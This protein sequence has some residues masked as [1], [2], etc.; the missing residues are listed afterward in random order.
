MPPKP[1]KVA[2]YINALKASSRMADQ[3]VTHRS[4]PKS[5]AQYGHPEAPWPD[6]I[7]GIL[8]EAGVKKLFKHQVQAID[9]IRRGENIVA[10]TP[11]A[12]GKTFM[13][14]LPVLEALAQDPGAHALYMFPLKALTQDQIK[15]FRK[16]AASMENG[17]TA[18]IY[19]GDTTSY[20]RRKI[21][22]APPNAI[23][24]NP[25][26]LHLGFLPYH[27]NWEGFFG[28]LKYIVVDE[29]HTYRGVMGSHMAW[30][31]ARLLRVCR[32]YGSDP[33]FVMCSAT[34]A[35]PRD[36]ACR[37]TGRDFKLV[38]K[39][40]APRGARHVVFMNP[41]TGPAQTAIMLLKAALA[42]GLRT[43]VYTQSRKM[44]EL[45]S[46]WASERAG[47]FKDKISA[48]RAGYLPEERRE[49]ETKLASGELL[50]V[51]ST[52]AL[53][54]GIDI[55]ALDLCILVGY[56]GTVMATWQRSGRV[57]RDLSESAM[58]LIAGEDALDQYFMRNP[59][60]FFSRSVENAV[61]NPLNPVISA[62]HIECAAAELP[63]NLDDP[64]LQSGALEKTIFGLEQEGKLLRDAK[65]SRLYASKKKPQRDVD[66]RGSGSQF[67]I[68]VAD[69]EDPEGP[70]GQS[71]GQ[72]DLFRAFRETHPGAIYLHL[73]RTYRVDALD[74]ARRTVFARP[75]QV[76]YYTQ[77]RGDKDT[78]ILE[79]FD[80]RTVWGTRVYCGRLK[81]TDKVTGFE[82][83]KV[84]T[85][86]SLGITPLDLPSNTFETQ[87]LWFEIPGHT[88]KA[89]ED[90]FMH[91]MGGIHAI[92]HAAIGIAPLIVMADRNDLGGISTP[93][94][95]QMGGPA[96]FIYD[97]VP[98][99]VGLSLIAFKKALELFAKTM[100][101]I[102]SCPCE[103]G[104]PSCV[105][106]PKCGSGNRPID[107]EASL[108]ILESIR[109]AKPEKRKRIVLNK[110]EEAN[111]A[112]EQAPPPEKPAINIQSSENKGVDLGQAYA[113]AIDA[114][115]Q[116]EK[117]HNPFKPLE[118]YGV[119]DIETRRS[120][121][122]VGGWGNAYRMGVSCSVLYDSRDDKFHEYFQDDT[123]ALAQHLTQLDLVVGF[124]IIRFDYQV[125]SAHTAFD[126]SAIPTLDM[127]QKIYGVLGYRISLDKLAQ[128]TLGTQKTADGLQALKWWKQGKMDKI[129][130]YCRADVAITRDLFLYGREHGHLLFQNK[131]KKVVR[132]PVK[133]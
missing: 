23:F 55:G 108:F 42:R 64:I 17:P 45:I 2:E 50:A 37:L 41:Q 87:G 93:F 91:F 31:F 16:L 43:I 83:K 76:D 5:R 84:R 79:I 69:P 8:Q 100:Q 52:S 81:V 117:E 85:R 89:V 112:A 61:I 21:K 94:H 133:W 75:A 132:V 124:N 4:F 12:S 28:K 63:L 125:L 59:E 99:G 10:A 74:L 103:T 104:C 39:S 40:T 20:R 90:K 9:L 119:L 22:E 47:E 13:Y 121:A 7:C 66:L 15:T 72:I 51:V 49:I 25:E 30:V 92:E 27:H 77:A 130:K 107:K 86:K 35:N 46:M 122:E 71:V 32:Y 57:G 95:P 109:G 129:L 54:L 98:G 18:E 118:N 53:E 73:G 33:Q 68:M 44:T 48:Y 60:D 80:E 96:V 1:D 36:L 19:D 56:P 11:T 3:V 111:K 97:G 131:A 38:E 106:S 128:H 101:A 62:R 126:F 127:L 116:P 29:V 6:P 105:H 114:F 82:S 24:T 120:A 58:V 102:K 88:Q 26:M 67:T 113:A 14:N 70:G 123:D 65:G 78:E 110:P 34:I 115:I